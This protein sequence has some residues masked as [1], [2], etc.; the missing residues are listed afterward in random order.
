[1]ED[2]LSV[3]SVTKKGKHMGTLETFHIYNARREDKQVNDNI[4]LLKVLDIEYKKSSRYIRRW[5]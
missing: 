1:M 2:V 5:S 4:I 3:P